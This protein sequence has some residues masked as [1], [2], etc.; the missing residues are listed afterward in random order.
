MEIYGGGVGCVGVLNYRGQ[1][2]KLGI[3][4][5]ISWRVFLVSHTRVKTSDTVDIYIYFFFLKIFDLFLYIILDHVKLT[6][7]TIVCW[8][9][10]SYHVS[11]G[12][13]GWLGFVKLSLWIAAN[14]SF[15]GGHHDHTLNLWNKS[16][17]FWL[18]MSSGEFIDETC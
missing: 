11:F 16:I 10:I 13:L 17:N 8:N 15:C 14:L 4:P 5:P 18:R 7:F 3:F 9:L 2:W 6:K 1:Q 12:V